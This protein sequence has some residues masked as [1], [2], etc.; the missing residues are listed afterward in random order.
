MPFRWYNYFV[1][2]NA[3]WMQRLRTLGRWAAC[4]G[5]LFLPAC[6]PA[7][8]QAPH[9]AGLVVAAP[10]GPLSAALETSAAAYAQEGGVPV[11]VVAM[12]SAEYAGQ[13]HAAL[14]AGLDRYDLVYL[15][16]EDLAKW[17]GYSA[18]QPLTG[19][20]DPAALQPWLPSVTVAGRMVGL[21]AQPDPAGLWYRADLL[22]AAGLSV[23]TGWEALRQTAQ[24][25]SAPPERVGI[26]TARR[27]ME[28][29]MD[30]AAVLAGFGGEMIDAQYQVQIEGEPALRALETYAALSAPGA[31]DFTRADV[32][33]ALQ[34]GR[35]AM[36]IAPYS[37]GDALLDCK[38]SRKVCREGQPLLA[39]ARLPGLAEQQAAGSLSAWAVPL[40]AAP[41]G[42][43][44]ALHRLAGQ[45]G[46]RARVV[47]GRGHTGPPRG[48]GGDG[49]PAG[50]GNHLPDGLPA[51]CCRRPA[52][53]SHQHGR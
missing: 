16:A 34:D 18:I 26:L 7:V 52:L 21:P 25:L 6:A 41:P 33:A 15:P 20:F 35:A 4:L 13:V 27:D 42:P 49:P 53:E 47:A 9:P 46:R 12:S 11:Q 14:L 10:R 31:E 44:P 1:K 39:W 19:K 40:H 32:L 50:A 51:G 3:V 30:F 2:N 5:L 29:G 22:Q 48:A 36:A 37:A 23:P 38:T 8:P 43:G 28:A 45:R 17:A 24:A